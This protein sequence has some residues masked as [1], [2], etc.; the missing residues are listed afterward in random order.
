MQL[1]IC[2]CRMKGY[3]KNGIDLGDRHFDLLAF[4]SGQVPHD[5]CPSTIMDD[6]DQWL[7]KSLISNL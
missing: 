4:S 7:R 2:K 6:Q 5:F 1:M 3:L